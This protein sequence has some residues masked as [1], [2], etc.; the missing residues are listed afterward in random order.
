[1]AKFI[2]WYFTTTILGVV[3]FPLT[4]LLLQRLPDKGYTIARVLGLFIWG[5]FFWIVG[6]IG[7]LRNDIGG[8]I[9]SLGIL[10]LLS[11]WATRKVGWNTLTSWM[12]RHR[13]VIITSELLFVFAFAV[14]TFVRANNPEIMGTEKPM[15]LAFI[16]A[17]LHSDAFPPHDPWL[18]G[19]TISYYYFGYVMVSMLAKL[20]ATA[21]SVAFNLAVSLVFAL[22]A[23]GSYGFVYNL[24]VCSIPAHSESEEENGLEE[25]ANS[26]AYLAALLGPF[27]TLI[28]SN[29]EGF[30]HYLHAQGVFWKTG[31]SGFWQ[32]LDILDLVD[33]PSGD[34]FGHWWWWRASRVIQDVDY[35]GNGKEVISEFPF[36]SYLLGDLHPHVL[37]M[38]FVFLC[39]AFAFNLFRHQEPRKFRWLGVLPIQLSPLIFAV[40][41]LVVGGMSFLNTWNFP[42]Y[43]AVLAGA[44][45]LRNFLNTEQEQSSIVAVLGDFLGLGIALGITGI[46]LYLP[47]YL[48][49]S[50]QA[51]GFIPNIIYVTRG[52]HL[53]VMF[54]PLFVPLFWYLFW[55]WKKHG[56]IKRARTGLAWGVGITGAL[57]SL[58]LFIVL[59]V[60]ILPGSLKA[61]LLNSLVSSG[62]TGVGDL[63]LEGFVRRVIW[64]GGWLTLTI[65]IALIIGLLWRYKNKISEDVKKIAP[66]QAFVLLL[67]LWATLLVLGPEFIFLRDL[68]GYRI[69][70][71]FKFYYQAWLLWSVVAAYGSVMLIRKLR[72]VPVSLFIGTML[73]VLGM[74]LVYPVKG[75]LSKTSKFAPYDGR[76]LDGAAYFERSSPDDA[77][78]AKW[79]AQAPF[80]VVAEAVGGSYSYAARIS[81]FS[82]QPTVLGWEY[83]EVQ[84]RGNS[85]KTTPRQ[86]DM[87]TLYCSHDWN[88]AQEIIQKYGIRY[89]VIGSF[90]YNT[91]QAGKYNCP[92]GLRQ[93]KFDRNLVITSRFG[94]TVIYSTK[95]T[96]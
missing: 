13:K 21:G 31:E 8:L 63:V 7:L 48:G 69:N 17:I 66:S 88:S 33:P 86:N 79:L 16:N 72:N 37:A 22:A 29:W 94:E 28:V 59:L 12:G 24:L 40:S 54:G 44:Y 51:G 89:I 45:A 50:S 27:F 42:I 82:G 47:F 60:E 25:K 46:V 95:E 14:W 26:F 87:T 80:G 78:A 55:L 65:M 18:S 35:M 20:T 96:Q 70:T 3:T 49:F 68:F 15:E 41:A 36:F 19:H 93:A 73:I 56:T 9:F 5:Y 52:I 83:H 91:Y 90:E 84:W 32:W 76:T 67:S 74:A 85:E 61:T 39:L 71:I 57:L 62:V 34:E 30:L 64:A 4:Y 81:T 11:V 77:A 2:F 53:W 58:M 38:P 6:I 1:M 43:V 23:L 75:L 92:N 10:L